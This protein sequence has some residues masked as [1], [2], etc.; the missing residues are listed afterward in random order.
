LPLWPWAYECAALPSEIWSSQSLGAL[1][2]TPY[3]FTSFVCLHLSP[4]AANSFAQ[5]QPQ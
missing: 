5:L 1:R 2:D 4:T 3:F